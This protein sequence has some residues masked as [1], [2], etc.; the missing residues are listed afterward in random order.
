MMISYQPTRPVYQPKRLNQSLQPIQFSHKPHVHGPDCDH[1]HHSKPES[2][3]QNPIVRFF[4]SIYQ[5]FK[6]ALNGIWT[7]FFGKNKEAHQHDEHCN[8]T[9]HTTE[10]HAH[11]H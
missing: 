11:H 9:S 8:H 1:A 6:E 10:K 3:T 2:E 7:D 4:D 5:W